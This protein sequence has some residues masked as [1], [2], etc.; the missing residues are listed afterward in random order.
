MKKITVFLFFIFTIFYCSGQDLRIDSLRAVILNSADDTIKVNA[1]NQLSILFW[2]SQPDLTI[3]HGRQ[4]RTL[5][6]EINYRKGMAYALK[7]MGMGY[8]TKGNY[9]EVL[10][11][12]KQS[13][14]AFDSIG[15][16]NG[17]SNILN[18]LGTIY[19]NQGDD[20][21]AIG[22]YLRALQVAEEVGEKLRIASALLNIGNVYLNKTETHDKSLNYLLRGLKIMEDLD[23]QDAIGTASVNI[24]EIYFLRDDYDSA[25][26]YFEKSL[27]AS[28]FDGSSNMPSALNN[29][30]MVYSA[31]EEYGK[32]ER[33][34]KE[35]LE[36]SR[37]FN[38]KLQEAQSLTGLGNAYKKQ[39]KYR[40]AVSIYREAESIAKEVGASKELKEVYEGISEAYAELRDYPSAFRYQTLLTEINLELY[41]AENDKKIERL[42]FSYE[43]E[44]KQDEIDLLAKTAEI[45]QLKT[46]RQRA[47]SMGLGIIGFLILILAG[48]LFNRYK[49]IHR[50]NKIIEAE[51]DRSENLLLNILPSETAE[52]LKQFGEAKARRYEMVSIL[53]TDF[54]G[55]TA[56]SA[57]L[58]PEEL[59]KEIHH[60][61][62]AFDDIMTRHGIEKIKTIGD[63]YMA[64]GGLPVPNE[65]HARDMV[66]AAIEI[67]EF[68]AHLKADRISRDEPF[69]E[70]RIGIHSGPVVAGIVGT[71]KFAYDIWGDTVNLASRM[72]SNSE[73]GKINI[74]ETTY[75][76][77]KDQFLVTPRG[78]INVKGGGDKGMY[79][80][81]EEIRQM[82]EIGSKLMA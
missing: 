21:Q 24:G 6:D 61:Y 70:I 43:I 10:E 62:K 11:S 66:R 69:F 80:V 26:F 44:K 36:I 77:V 23:E 32:S 29:L 51:K 9:V 55:F 49:F 81:G 73:P 17:V 20:A 75:Q 45:E 7:N 60:C 31:R 37:R 19:T 71:K 33:Y 14:A 12:W 54:K 35:A 18:N 58:S 68:M 78:N 48:G 41:N 59:V 15:D 3:Q 13:L 79:F 22:F 27:S 64:A 57:N 56:I 42:Q 34:H 5:S 38:D 39:Q 50:T 8:Y 67:R 4:A 2:E 1:L 74:S 82:A 76:L 52:E 16:M 65:T 63:A 46:K 30:G 25:L 53:F 72:E 40:E 28:Q 47:I